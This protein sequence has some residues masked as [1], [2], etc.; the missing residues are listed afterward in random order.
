MTDYMAAEMAYI[1]GKR[2]LCSFA[3]ACGLTEALTHQPR[4][5][6]SENI[7]LRHGLLGTY[8]VVDR[9]SCQ[10]IQRYLMDVLVCRSTESISRTRQLRLTGHSWEP[11]MLNLT[12]IVDK[13]QFVVVHRDHYLFG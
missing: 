7:M 10:C 5:W 6:L 1:G 13:F 11:F 4:F 2:G 9:N 8:A 3:L 12:V